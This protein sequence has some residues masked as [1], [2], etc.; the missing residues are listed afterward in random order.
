MLHLGYAA[1]GNHAVTGRRSG[2][3]EIKPPSTAT[4]FAKQRLISMIA[5]ICGL[6]LIAHGLTGHADRAAL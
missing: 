1:I 3:M 2:P 4:L 6:L 5:A